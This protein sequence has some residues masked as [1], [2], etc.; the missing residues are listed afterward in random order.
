MLCLA[1]CGGS[2][3]FEA[4]LLLIP[5]VGSLRVPDMGHTQDYGVYHSVYDSFAW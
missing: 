5:D 3:E 4:P 2:F 1:S